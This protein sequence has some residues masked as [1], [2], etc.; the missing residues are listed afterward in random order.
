MRMK[1]FTPCSA[2][3]AAILMFGTL[4]G[5]STWLSGA[6]ASAQSKPKPAAK[7]AAP[8][9]P[10]AAPAKPAS[11]PGATRPATGSTKPT[12]GGT[13]TKPTTS[14][15]KPTTSNPKPTTGNPTGKT[16]TEGNPA[17]RTKSTPTPKG[18]QK[19]V[20]KNGAEVTKRANGKV[21][22]VHDAKRGMDIH[23][24]LDGGRR[25]SVERRDGSRLVV[26][27]GRPGYVQR[28]YN[29]HGHE[30]AHRDYYY[31]G[32]HYDR[33]YRGYAYRGIYLNAY[34]PAYY[35]SPGFYGWAYNPWA[36]PV[37]YGWGWAGSP[38]LGFYGGYFTPYSVYPSSAF[39]L[40]DYIISQNLQAAYAA[41]AADASD[42]GAAQQAAAGATPLTPEVKQLIADE[43]KSQLALENA[44]ATQSAQK[45]DVD[46]S[47]SGIARLLADGKPHM[48]VSGSGLDVTDA[49][50]G[51]ECHIS[52]GDALEMLQPPPAAATAANLIVKAS[53]GGVEC[54]A[55]ETV[56]VNLTDL[57]EMQNHMRENIDAG[58]KELQAKQGQGGLPKAPAS[59]QAAP[60]QPEFV[61][62]APPAPP[63]DATDIQAQSTAAD[64]AES[65]AHD[66][67]H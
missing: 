29:Y 21:A 24:G 13:P 28:G 39:W 37:A 54:V 59:A 30:F 23:H 15:P 18:S 53:K 36:V 11:T 19:T 48:F 62:I 8:A 9:R 1:D 63:A 51:N 46:A 57:Q 38:W 45:Q 4:L 67:S 66:T 50:S 3:R 47:S 5:L 60:T 32:R 25:V 16:G 40:T 17:T 52:D 20:A 14:N 61:A 65:E 22:D 64:Q 10:A 2:N 6:A 43:V 49:S 33:Y 41:R 26:E 35:Y 12:T 31:N 42:A 34:A 58:L 44:E 7:P 56:Q 27:R 55:G